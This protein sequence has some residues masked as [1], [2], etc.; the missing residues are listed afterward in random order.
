MATLFNKNTSH[1]ALKE[2]HEKLKN[3]WSEASE[4]REV[5]KGPSPTPEAAA[6]MSGG[7]ATETASKEEVATTATGKFKTSHAGSKLQCFLC[8]SSTLLR[9]NFRP[10]GLFKTATQATPL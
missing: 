10:I 8:V 3:C 7:V 1:P 2:E 4:D 6:A 5:L 9:P